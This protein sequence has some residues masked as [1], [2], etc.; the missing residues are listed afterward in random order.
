MHVLDLG[1]AWTE[2]TGLPFVWAVWLGGSS[3]TSELAEKLVN[4][5]EEGLRNLDSIIE[6]LQPS[7]YDL[8][9]YFHQCIDFELNSEHKKGLAKFGELLIKHQLLESVQMPHFVAGTHAQI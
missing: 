3:L 9:D 2:M 4:A 8:H 7:N 6:G 5:K 1:A